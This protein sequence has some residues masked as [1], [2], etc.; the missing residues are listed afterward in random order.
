MKKTKIKP[1]EEELVKQLLK[2]GIK[3]KYPKGSFIAFTAPDSIKGQKTT[4]VSCAWY[5]KVGDGFSNKDIVSRPPEWQNIPYERA[6]E[7]ADLFDD[8]ILTGFVYPVR[9]DGNYPEGFEVAKA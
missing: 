3:A 1:T 8:S 2:T 6:L 4:T 9:E 7:I 5:N